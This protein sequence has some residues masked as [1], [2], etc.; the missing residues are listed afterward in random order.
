MKANTALQVSDMS[1]DNFVDLGKAY[2]WM[3][4]IIDPFPG[5]SKS[6]IYAKSK[7]KLI[8]DMNSKKIVCI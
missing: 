4:D 3:L 8:L 7:F 2:F 1:V 5:E 6:S